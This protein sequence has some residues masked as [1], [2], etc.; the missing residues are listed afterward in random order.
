MKELARLV[1]KFPEWRRTIAFQRQMGSPYIG[2]RPE[3]KDLE[4]MMA[5][6]E[7]LAKMFPEET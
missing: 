5:I 7:K 2:F 4:E 6:L 3:I 1:A